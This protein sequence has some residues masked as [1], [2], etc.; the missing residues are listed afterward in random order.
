MLDSSQVTDWRIK[1]TALAQSV[2]MRDGRPYPLRGD[3]AALETVRGI[4]AAVERQPT[5]MA[6]RCAIAVGG[7]IYR[8][9]IMP[10]GTIAAR[11]IPDFVP[12]MEDL[13]IGKSY[14]DLLLDPELAR[15]GGL[16]LVT[17]AAGSGKSH[18]AAA[19]TTDYLRSGFSNYGLTYENPIEFQMEGFHGEG[20]LDQN[21]IPEG[22]YA[23]ALSH[24]LR[25]FPANSRSVL[26]VGEILDSDAA[27]ELCKVF[28]AGH[29]VV[30]TLHGGNIISAMQ[31][32][33]SLAGAESNKA[34]REVIALSLRRVVHQELVRTAEGV[35]VRMQPLKVS[36]TAQQLIAQGML[37]NLK[38]PIQ[39]TES[40]M[41]K[42]PA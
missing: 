9:E 1:P 24:C 17:G 39:V 33:F 29:L 32:L 30:S 34:I 7:E 25:C 5:A 36:V 23:Y 14:R 26:F 10:N 22:N 27:I 19:L 4:A 38:D 12:T 16:I 13:R 42:E 15:K 21:N 35:R 8:I 11:A 37:Q 2:F 20:Y 31:R 18:T 41:L 40:A 6:R 3:E 28:L